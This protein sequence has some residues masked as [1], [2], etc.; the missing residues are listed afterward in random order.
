MIGDVCR[1]GVNAAVV[2]AFARYTIRAGHPLPLLSRSGASPTQFGR[3]GSLLGVLDAPVFHE[4]EVV[5]QPGDALVLFTDGVT[6]GRRGESFFGAAGLDDA[7]TRYVG[8][9]P[10]LVHGILDDVMEFQSGTPRDD[11]AI[12]VVRLPDR[13]D[14]DESKDD[15]AE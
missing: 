3:A 11:I 13:P 10:A 14:H 7:V 9:A 12:V 6:A 5:M 4:V 1:K 15:Q 8:P 2:T